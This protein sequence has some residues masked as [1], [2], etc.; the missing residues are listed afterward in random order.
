MASRDGVVIKTGL[1][2]LPYLSKRI[3]L[4]AHI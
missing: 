3:V 1:V 2:I 4:A